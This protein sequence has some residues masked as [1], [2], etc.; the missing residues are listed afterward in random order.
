[1]I[2]FLLLY[3]LSYVRFVFL[4]LR[5]SNEYKKKKIAKKK[6]NENISHLFILHALYVTWDIFS[7]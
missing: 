5:V 1:M 2:I 7:F 6:A 4:F 3:Q